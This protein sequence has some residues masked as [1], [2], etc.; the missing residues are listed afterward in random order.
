MKT[1]RKREIKFFYHRQQLT[2]AKTLIV[3]RKKNIMS[4]S[5]WAQPI[6]LFN[7]LKEKKN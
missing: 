7:D 5:Y 6:R 2:A 4:D 3:L 1:A